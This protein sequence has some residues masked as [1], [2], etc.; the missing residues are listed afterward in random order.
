MVQA[1]VA[2]RGMPSGMAM[3]IDAGEVIVAIPAVMMLAIIGEIAVL[4]VGG[5]QAHV[6]AQTR[7]AMD[8]HPDGIGVVGAH[9]GGAIGAGHAGEV[10]GAVVVEGE[11]LSQATM[12]LHQ[13]V[14]VVIE[15]APVGGVPALLVDGIDGVWRAL[16]AIAS[17]LSG[18]VDGSK[19]PVLA[20][21]FIMV[22]GQGPQHTLEVFCGGCRGLAQ[23]V[24][25]EGTQVIGGG[26]EV[27]SCRNGHQFAM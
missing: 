25:M 12:G 4:V 5:T 9:D 10:V 19:T 24:V 23:V 7:S 15:E 27:V 11:V 8:E 3:V 26:D 21:V 20:V 16:M 22:G 17:C 18:M 14:G 2:E 1:I 6:L 13:T